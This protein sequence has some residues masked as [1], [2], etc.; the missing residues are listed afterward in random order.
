MEFPQLMAGPTCESTCSVITIPLSAFVNAP[1]VSHPSS[2]RCRC[3]CS[4]YCESGTG[5]G[6]AYWLDSSISRVRALPE[7]VNP[8]TAPTLPMPSDRLTCM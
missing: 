4:M 6:P 3:T 2:G 1:L 8:N 5:A 7:S